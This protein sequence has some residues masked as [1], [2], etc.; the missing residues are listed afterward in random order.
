LPPLPAG[1]EPVEV[2]A[3]LTWAWVGFWRLSNARPP[4]LNGPTRIL[5]SEIGAYCDLHGFDYGKRQD[6]LFY[7]QRLDDKFM[8]IAKKRQEEEERKQQQNGAG[9]PPRKGS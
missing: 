3:D 1:P 2:Y 8:E 7:V 5:F 9:R 4:G 6:F